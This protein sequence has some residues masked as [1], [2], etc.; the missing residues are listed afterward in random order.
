MQSLETEWRALEPRLGPLPFQCFDW[1]DSWWRH[2]RANRVTIQDRL[3]LRVF[4]DEH[5]NLI[6]AAPLMLTVCP[7]I[8]PACI[9]RL[10]TFGADSNI[11]EIRGIVAP[12]A[13]ESS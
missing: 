3:R 4:R 7:G 1:V 11:T 12:P 13:L 8:G 2:L 6:G 5:S 9:R 10:Q